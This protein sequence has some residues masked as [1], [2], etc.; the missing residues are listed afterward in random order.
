MGAMVAIRHNQQMKQF[1]ERLKA[2]GK[3][4]TSQTAVMRKL[5][6]IAYSLYKNNEKYNVDKYNLA[7][8]A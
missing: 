1:F 5:I 6:V 3:H 7:I 8:G 4:T 2:N